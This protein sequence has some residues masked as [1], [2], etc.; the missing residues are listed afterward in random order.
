MRQLVS[1]VTDEHVVYVLHD[2]DAAV[3]VAQVVNPGLSVPDV[4]EL[5]ASLAEALRLNGKPRRVQRAELPPAPPAEKP[6]KPKASKRSQA[7]RTRVSWGLTREQV[8]DDIR[9]HPDTTTVE[10]AVRLLGGDPP[11][12]RAVQS[13]QTHVS[14]VAKLGYRFDRRT[15]VETHHSGQRVRRTRLTLSGDPA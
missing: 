13:V 6:T 4:I 9:A 3:Q 7:Q 12:D 5:G 11:D 10:I 15:V 14:A 1:V 2:G 8:L